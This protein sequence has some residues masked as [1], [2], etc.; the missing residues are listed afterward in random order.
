MAGRM[1]RLWAIALAAGLVACV[2]DAVSPAQRANEPA[3]RPRTLGV[4]EITIS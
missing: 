2:D 4:V 3:A 1:N